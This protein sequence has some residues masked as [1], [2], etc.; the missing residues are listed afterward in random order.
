MSNIYLN[1]N[2]ID[3]L[4]RM[5]TGLLSEVWIMRDRMAIMEK[6]YGEKLG[7]SSKDLDDFVPTGDLSKDLETL[8]DRMV[9]NVVGA[10]IA[11][12]ERSVDAILERALLKRPT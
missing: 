8:R 4:A 7:I 6:L 9:N 11:A 2:N 1:E 5:L 3:D 10:P 12:R